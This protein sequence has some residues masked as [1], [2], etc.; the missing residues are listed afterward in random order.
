M[1]VQHKIYIYIYIHTYIHTSTHTCVYIRIHYNIRS[2][3]IDLLQCIMSY[4]GILQY[5]CY[6]IT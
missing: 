4:D 2:Y 5:V 1:Y 6:I 3:S